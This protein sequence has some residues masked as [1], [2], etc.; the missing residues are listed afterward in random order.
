[1]LRV[2][3]M[4]AQMLT[5]YGLVISMGCGTSGRIAYMVS[6]RYQNLLKNTNIDYIC[7]AGDSALLLLDEMPEDD[8]LLGIKDLS[9]REDVL[10]RISLASRVV[11]VPPM[12][13]DHLLWH[14]HRVVN[15]R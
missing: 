1:M 6:K 10:L 11:L 12:W 3:E 14:W 4:I 5:N 8:P 9:L 2:S 7:A 15:T 13:R